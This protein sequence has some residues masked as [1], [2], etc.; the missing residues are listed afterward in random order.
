MATLDERYAHFEHRDGVAPY[1]VL[2]I[3]DVRRA[4]RRSL[5]TRS[6]ARRFFDAVKAQ[7]GEHGVL[8]EALV[9]DPLHLYLRCEE[10]PRLLIGAPLLRLRRGPGAATFLM[11]FV[12]RRGVLPEDAPD[13]WAPGDP[14]YAP[15]EPRMEIIP[16]DEEMCGGA[17]DI[18]E[19]HGRW[20]VDYDERGVR[21]GG[22]E[23]SGDRFTWHRR[24][25]TAP[26]HVD[27]LSRP[28]S[29][30]PLSL[31]ARPG[32]RPSGHDPEELASLLLPTELPSRVGWRVH[33]PIAVPMGVEALVRIARDALRIACFRGVIPHE[34]AWIVADG[35]EGTAVAGGAS[36]DEAL[37]R[38]EQAV[39]AKKPRPP[40]HTDETPLP[41]PREPE[42]PSVR[43]S[44]DGK[45][46]TIST[47]TIE[48]RVPGRP[49]P[50][51][52]PRAVPT[53]V[54]AV[55]LRVPRL[56]PVPQMLG[57]AGFVRAVRCI[58][59]HGTVGHLFVRDEP[60]GFTAVGEHVI[61]LVDVERLD[62]EIEE[63]ERRAAEDLEIAAQPGDELFVEHRSIYALF[64]DGRRART[65]PRL[66]QGSRTARL[67]P[68]T[69]DG[70][71]VP[72]RL[73]RERRDGEPRERR[74]G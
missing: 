41:P 30:T 38:F 71:V 60:N 72:W 73:V 23:T 3:A 36:A 26:Y 29:R 69:L 74:D 53:N 63:A 21:A 50:F 64:D 49:L 45:R 24:P 40:G 8:D 42:G 1:S 44:E 16:R 46:T 57:E 9:P 13:G 31:L 43:T 14:P 10:D 47:G 65:P 67:G 54:P 56:P 17:I 32:L 27:L 25:S 59:E 48:L 39:F 20:T 6:H 4:L 66:E 61:D 55:L 68:P 12:Y 7:L 28:P 18:L 51:A 19:G 35:I 22:M 2:P 11:H 58:G 15:A 62:A 5:A 70:D 52:W 37:A 33:R 34:A